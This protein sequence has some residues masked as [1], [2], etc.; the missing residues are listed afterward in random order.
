MSHQEEQ[1]KAQEAQIRSVEKKLSAS[2]D[3]STQLTQA[4][5]DLT[6]A[7]HEPICPAK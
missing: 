3:Q 5:H 6:T 2:L 4:V 1:T 7:I